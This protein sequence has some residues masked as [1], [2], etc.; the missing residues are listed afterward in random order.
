MLNHLFSAGL[1]KPCYQRG[2]TGF[3]G[4]RRLKD[5][6]H[7]WTS[8][9]VQALRF[10]LQSTSGKALVGSCWFLTAGK[11]ALRVVWGEGLVWR[12]F[13][14]REGAAGAGNRISLQ[15]RGVWRRRLHREGTLSLFPH[16]ESEA[17]LPRQP[18]AGPRHHGATRWR[19]RAAPE[20]AR[21]G[22]TLPGLAWV[23]RSWYLH[24]CR[25][26]TPLW[27][28]SGKTLRLR[29]KALTQHAVLNHDQQDGPTFAAFGDAS[30]KNR[31]WGP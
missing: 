20:Q 17:A 4:I 29:E 7:L 1:L 14:W 23:K 8:R 12:L 11:S 19:H 9:Q 2:G 30:T 27:R 24:G 25:G 31:G 15:E 28:R 22:G 26:E 10:L 13:G 3:G 18:P 21:A 6:Q 5:G 16:P